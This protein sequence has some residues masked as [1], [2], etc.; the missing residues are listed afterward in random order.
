MID[1]ATP[2]RPDT[3]EQLTGLI[4]RITFH[5]EESGFAVFKVKVRGHKDFVTVIGMLPEVKAGEW[6]S[7]QGGWVIDREY[8]QQFKAVMLRT[9][10]PN[11]GEGMQKYLA[12]GLIKGIGPAMAGRLVTA[13]NTKVFEVIEQTPQRLLEVNGIGS[14]R[15]GRIVTAWNDQKIVREIMVFLHSHGVSTSRAFRIYKT[16]GTDAISTV[17]ED[18]YRLARDI[19]GI[20]FKTADQIAEKLGIGKQSDLRARAGVEFVLQ[21]LTD[22]GHCAFPRD[23]LVSKSEKMLEIPPAIIE[24]AIDHGLSEARLVQRPDEEGNPLV[25]LSANDIAERRLAE[26]LIALSKGEHPCPP[27]D[28]DKAI[29]W[30][31]GKAGFPLAEAQREAVKLAARSKVMVITG[32]PGVGKTTLVNGIVQILQAKKLDVVLCAPTGRAAKRMTETTGKEAKTIHRMLEFDPAGGGFKHNHDNPLDGDVFVIDETSM[33]DLQLAHQTIRAI[34]FH[35]AVI[36]VGDVDQLPSVGPGSVLRDIIESGVVPVCRLTEVF[37]QAAQS[38]IIT[39]A[40]RI[41]H[42]RTPLYPQRKVQDV[43][44]SDFYFFP[45]DDPEQAVVEIVRLVH[46]AIPQRFGVNAI[47]DMQVLTPMQRGELGARNL[48][49][50][51]QEALNPTGPSIQ[52]FGWIFRVGDKVMQNVNDYEKDVFNGD[53]GR[54]VGIDEVEQEVKVQYENREVAYDFNEMDELQPSYAVTIHKS[55]GSEYPVVV[56]P[57]HTQHYMLLQRN[58]LY[59]AVTRG[60]KLVVLVGTKKAIAIA[61]KQTGSR[62]RVTT[63]K[64]RLVE[65]AGV[66][67][68][69]M[70]N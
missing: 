26:N 30:V 67:A 65:Q 70:P 27:I 41:N 18:P 21:E 15:Q 43:R 20:G 46:E 32:G 51:L 29:E 1:A 4:E 11:T 37:R 36:L 58:L 60:K 7:A 3:L 64:T 35:A 62:R 56:V 44:E 34:P 38:S 55:Q 6:V 17:Q 5:N 22:E 66:A 12:S 23:G 69:M 63:L 47:N 40:H 48:N 39:N 50:V 54:I 31:E 59:T 13:F 9:A 45:T 25:Y 16:Y 24:S 57:I 49:L 2:P 42:G 61:V 53:I 19:R 10:P 8:G 14:T 68:R 28:M 33:V 52:R